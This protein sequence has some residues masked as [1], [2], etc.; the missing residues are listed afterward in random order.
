ML[1]ERQQ[2]IPYIRDEYVG[3]SPIWH[4]Q[5]AELL[6][7]GWVECV[8]ASP[9]PSEWRGRMGQQLHP[10]GTEP[11]AGARAFS[12]ATGCRAHGS[13]LGSAGCPAAGPTW[14]QWWRLLRSHPASVLPS[15]RSLQVK[16][17]AVT[18]WHRV[19]LSKQALVKCVGW[20]AVQTKRAHHMQHST[21]WPLVLRRVL[22]CLATAGSP[23]ADSRAKKL[24]T[25]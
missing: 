14:E 6:V 17:L 4:F 24:C 22:A 8:R 13:G 18:D 19:G 20:V 16:L 9:K 1:S 21:A 23:S 2:Q 3:A 11:P 15:H 12:H 5:V 10:L 25:I 7:R